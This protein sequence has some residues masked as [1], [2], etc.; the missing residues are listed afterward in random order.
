[1]EPSAVLAERLL[2]QREWLRELARGLVGENDADDLVQE[3]LVAALEHPSNVATPRAWLAAVAHRLASNVRRARGRR[4]RRESRA[5]RPEALP[6]TDELVE[7]VDTEQRLVRELLGLREPLRTTLLL[8]FHEGLRAEEIAR[9]TGVPAGTVRWRTKQGLDEL[10]ERLAPAYGGREGLALALVPLVRAPAGAGAVTATVAGG[11]LLGIQA[12]LVAAAAA[13]VVLAVGV[14]AWRWTQ[15]GES[16]EKP[17]SAAV[18]ALATDRADTTE[19]RA[20][21]L[22]PPEADAGRAPVSS[23]S[24]I[25]ELAPRLRILEFDGTPNAEQRVAI[26]SST[27][28]DEERKTDA[29]GWVAMPAR[30]AHELLIT[31][32]S[33][34]A[35]RTSLEI[36]AGDQTLTLPEG[37]VLEGR[38]LVDGAAP[39]RPLELGVLD[40]ADETLE[41]ATDVLTGDSGGFRL[42]GLFA[43]E[44]YIIVLPRGHARA[45]LREYTSPDE[46]VRIEIPRPERG[47]VLELDRIASLSGRLVEADGRTPTAG[48]LNANFTWRNGTNMIAGA[49][50]GEDGRFELF[51]EAPWREVDI[52]Y[53]G[54]PGQRGKTSASF[55]IEGARDGELGDLVLGGGRDLVLRVRDR[56]GRPIAGARTDLETAPT[57]ERGET[58]IRGSTRGVVRVGACGYRVESVDLGGANDVIEVELARVA[59]LLVEVRARG[60]EPVV[61]ATVELPGDGNAESLFESDRDPASFLSPGREGQMLARNART[62]YARGVTDERGLLR[63]DVL[64]P[65]RAIDLRVIARGG[66]EL[67]EGAVLHEQTLP[68]LAPEECRRVAIDLDEELVSVRGRVLDLQGR[69]VPFADVDAPGRSWGAVSADRRGQFAFDVLD[70]PDWWLTVSKAGLRSRTMDFAVVPRDELEVVLEPAHQLEVRVVDENGQALRGGRLSLRQGDVD[71]REVG[72][73]HFVLADLADGPHELELVI[74]GMRYRRVV[75]D[76]SAVE[77]RVPTMGAVAVRWSLPEE[78]GSEWVHVELESTV[79]ECLPLRASFHGTPRGAERFDPVLPGEYELVLELSRDGREDGE[80]T[81]RTIVVRAGETTTVDL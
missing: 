32:A 49:S 62:F 70:V 69:P 40:S 13:L 46:R 63:F 56:E 44:P 6:T 77:F 12:K 51:L 26:L 42:H 33:A 30:G 39:R 3:T 19:V 75:A 14:G 38:V 78:E 8:R 23:T 27:G 55:A 10:R 67:P 53:W 61:N 65:G 59:G 52:E 34:M 28:A 5:A 25:A 68:P 80:W 41:L 17:E 74:G 35:Y 43:E 11:V 73:G 4:R 24:R 50:A 2:A 22:A 60:G 76:E 54:S 72:P 47:L 57:D 9:R 7:R 21:V 36:A 15:A 18:A 66:R 81:R 58:R 79:S 16:A 37:A 71:A 1:M 64:R 31:R 29:N 20:D 45:G 48:A